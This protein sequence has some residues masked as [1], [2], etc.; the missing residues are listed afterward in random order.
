[1]DSGLQL[2]Q[3]QQSDDFLWDQSCFSR[4]SYQCK[5]SEVTKMDIHVHKSGKYFWNECR[6]RFAA[7]HQ[8]SADHRLIRSADRSAGLQLWAHLPRRVTSINTGKP[9]CLHNISCYF[10]IIVLLCSIWFW[11]ILLLTVAVLI[12]L[13]ITNLSKAIISEDITLHF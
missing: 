9:L 6:E 13:C 4:R 5:G 8:R 11:G 10:V 7:D 2:L 12:L 3:Q 1:M